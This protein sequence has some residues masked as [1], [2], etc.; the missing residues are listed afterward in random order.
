M[1]AAIDILENRLTDMEACMRKC[2]QHGNVEDANMIW[3][4]IIDIRYAIDV[5]KIKNGEI[6]EMS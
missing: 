1:K 3:G 5:I 6:N 2:H 4:K